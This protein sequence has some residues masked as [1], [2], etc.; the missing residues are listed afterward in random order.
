MN[1]QATQLG[2]VLAASIPW[3]TLLTSAAGFAMVVLWV[4]A[5]FG[6][7]GRTEMSARRRIAIAT[8]QADRRT[9]FEWTML[10][11]LMWMLLQLTEKLAVPRTKQRLN[12]MLVAAGSPSFYTAEECL[13][14][15]LLW[16]LA[17][18]LG[19]AL[20]N[21]LLIGTFSVVALTL[22]MLAGVFVPLV[23][24]HDMA[25]RRVREISRR[26]PYSLD[27]IGLAM[28]AGSTFTEAVQ[29]VV[30]EDPV[31]PMNVELSTV[32]GEIN[33]GTTRRGA[34]INLAERVPLESLR[35]IV[36][37]IIQAEEL[38]TP[39][40]EVLKSQASLLRMHRS[41]RA[42]KLAALASVR[43]LIPSVLILLSVVLTVFAPVIIRAIRNELF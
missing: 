12:G 20:L 27:L 41:V 26:V 17:G 39:L 32:L 34:L 16:S 43:I 7:Q 19:L 30:R 9:P 36:A 25:R 4:L 23:Y 11:P 35:G 1:A 15:M 5:L 40:T 24:F 42:E 37:S 3:L 38:G 14:L 33:L 22:G 10:A 18:G 2:G 21:L 13:A 31:Q 6:H 29:T 28:G 8:G